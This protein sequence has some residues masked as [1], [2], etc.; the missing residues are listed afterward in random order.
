MMKASECKCVECGKQ[1]V[2]FWPIIDTDIPA[3]PYCRSCLD[4][5]KAEVVAKAFGLPDKV[6]KK[7]IKNYKSHETD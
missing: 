4:K 3:H 7:I 6:A 1:A 5:A 2:A